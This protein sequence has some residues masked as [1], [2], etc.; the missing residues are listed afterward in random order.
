VGG[1]DVAGE[2]SFL[3]GLFVLPLLGGLGQQV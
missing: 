1:D 3:L 2:G